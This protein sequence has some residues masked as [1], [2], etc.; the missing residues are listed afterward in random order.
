MSR[1]IPALLQAT[2]ELESTYLNQL[3][4]MWGARQEQQEVLDCAR[5]DAAKGHAATKTMSK[6]SKNIY[7]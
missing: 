3:S 1:L 6:V 7:F 2:G 5:A 4:T